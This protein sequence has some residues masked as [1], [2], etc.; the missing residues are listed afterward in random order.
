VFNSIFATAREGMAVQA[1]RV[2]AAAQVIASQGA[3]EPAPDAA[4]QSS[5][6]RIGALPVG[7]TIQEAVVTLVEAEAAYKA[8]VAVIET[9][10]SMFDSLLDAVDHDHH[11]DE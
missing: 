9:A 2:E 5:G 1:Q 11:D 8:N 4:V 3:S 6:V 7:T 10:A